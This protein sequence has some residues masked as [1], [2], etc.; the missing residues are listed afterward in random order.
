MTQLKHLE[1]A[2]S[3]ASRANLDLTNSLANASNTLA[4]AT[5]HAPP[6]PTVTPTTS[7]SQASPAALAVLKFKLQKTELQLMHLM[8]Q[9]DAVVDAISLV[10]ARHAQLQAGQRQHAV[11]VAAAKAA[12]PVT[13]PD[14]QARREELKQLTWKRA[15]LESTV[16]QQE[17][18]LAEVDAAREAVRAKEAT[19]AEA[20]N[21]VSELRVKL[22][23]DRDNLEGMRDELN[24]GVRPV[25]EK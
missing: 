1:E 6:A 5:K 9:R 18:V 23:G 20:A 8:G 25:A 14:L 12:P 22:E 7:S 19:V 17:S 24:E 2:I 16:R 10:E 11:D 21:Q 3:D 4:D 15:K 13:H